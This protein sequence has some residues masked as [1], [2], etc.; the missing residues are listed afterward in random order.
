[1]VFKEKEHS[2]KTLTLITAKV[3]LLETVLSLLFNVKTMDNC[4][5]EN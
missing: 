1:M 3:P 5:L 2:F 4:P